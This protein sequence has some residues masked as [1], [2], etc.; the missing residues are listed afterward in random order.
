MA[1]LTE[2]EKML[3]AALRAAWHELNTIR[4][5][6][7]VA[8][9]REYPYRGGTPYCAEEAWGELTNRCAKAI[10]AATGEPPKP[11]PFTWEAE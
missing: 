7:G 10:E 6:D 5:R 8:Y 11:W 1:P 9:H 4:A 3:V 2:T